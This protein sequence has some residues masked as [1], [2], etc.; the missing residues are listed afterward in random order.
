MGEDPSYVFNT[1]C[2]SIDIANNVLNDE[3]KEFNPFTKY[4]GTG[5]ILILIKVM[6]LYFNIL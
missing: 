2:P 6:L 5:Q 4:S 1:G 3:I